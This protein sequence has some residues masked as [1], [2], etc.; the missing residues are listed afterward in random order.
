MAIVGGGRGDGVAIVHL[1]HSS[2]Q[3]L[4]FTVNKL[5]LW[6]CSV[7]LRFTICMLCDMNH[8]S[9]LH[10]VTLARFARSPSQFC[11]TEIEKFNISA[12]WRTIW[13]KFESRHSRLLYLL[14]LIPN[15]YGM[16]GA[17]VLFC[18]MPFRSSAAPQLL[19]SI[20]RRCVAHSR[21]IAQ[22]TWFF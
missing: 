1:I 15:E 2:S 10:V 16:T 20:G 14:R 22:M 18:F 6:Q 8:C 5:Q 13:E 21:K 7:L 19:I 3:C 17:M 9:T 11:K 12:K 4:L